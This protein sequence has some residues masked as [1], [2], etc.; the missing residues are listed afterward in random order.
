MLKGKKTLVRSIILGLLVVI[1]SVIV[2]KQ[3]SNPTKKQPPKI[4]FRIKTVSVKPLELGVNT[5]S[6]EA[7]GR[8]RAYRRFDVFAEVNGVLQNE[9][10]RE[11]TSFNSGEVLVKMNDEELAVQLKAQKS[12]LLGL[13]SQA[14]PDI[15]IDYKEE[16]DNWKN[17][18][19]ALSPNTK[20]PVLPNSNNP[21]LKQ[22]LAS[23]NIL[24]SYYS[25]QAQEVRLSKY[26][27][28]T[29]FS[30]ILSEALIEP[31]ALVRAGQKIG[32]FVQP[33]V[34]ELETSVTPE[35]LVYLKKTS[36]IQ[37][38]TDAGEVVW[39]TISRINEVVEG[40]TQLVS[41]YLSI[42]DKRV[43]EGQFLRTRINGAS[44]NNSFLISRDMINEDGTIFIVRNSDS[45]LV[46]KPVKLYSVQGEMAL[47]SGVEDGD[48][49]PLNNISGAFESMKVIPSII[50]K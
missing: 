35:E 5:F 28:I 19:S 7:S 10:Y 49:I 4:S 38:Y 39:G 37:L 23:R 15:Q 26:N 18:A 29:P 25:I 11:G 43:R 8:L 45:T 1:L 2:S 50:E 6:V 21:K 32:T 12:S 42:S 9:S 46:K 48:L 47:I 30:G 13:I 17:F 34:Y 24:N 14:L 3:L 33:G 40:S 31:G 16:V 22:F 27:I 20:L 36:K 41:V 44:I